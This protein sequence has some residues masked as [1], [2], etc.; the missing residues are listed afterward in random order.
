M[1]FSSC[2]SIILDFTN[3]GTSTDLEHDSGN[4]GICGPR[5]GLLLYP[6]NRSVVAYPL[7][8]NP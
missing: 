3:H 1:F 7:Y 4:R 5:P 8:R 2:T 6:E